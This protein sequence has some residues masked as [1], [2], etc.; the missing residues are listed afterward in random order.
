MRPGMV[1]HVN[2]FEFFLFFVHFLPS[3]VCGCSMFDPRDGVRG[4][5]LSEPDTYAFK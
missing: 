5:Y 3:L 4:A 1:A 2:G